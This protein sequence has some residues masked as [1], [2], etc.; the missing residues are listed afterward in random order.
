MRITIVLPIL[1]FLFLG[2]AGAILRPVARVPT[3]GAAGFE[4]IPSPIGPLLASAHFWDGKSADMSAPSILFTLSASPSGNLTLSELQRFPTKG[5]H[6]W[7]FFSIPGEFGGSFLV[8]CNYYGCGSERGPALGPCKST[9]IY[10]FREEEGRFVLFQELATAGPAQTDHIVLPSGEAYLLVGENFNDEVC[11]FRYTATQSSS[12]FA[13]FT[14]LRVPGAGAM[15]VAEAGG[16]I[17]L[18]L[19]SYFDSGWKTQS[20]VYRAATA[21]DN[22][23][24]GSSRD[25]P[26]GALQWTLHQTLPTFGAH[27]ADSALIGGTEYLFVSE[28]RDDASSRVSSG[29]YTLDHATGQYGL[30]Q[31]IPTDG[32]HGGEL[33][34]GPG[35]RPYLAIANFGDRQGARYAARSSVWRGEAGGGPFALVAEVQTQGATDVEHFA[36]SGRHYIAFAEE[37]NLGR[38]TFQRSYIYELTDAS[39]GSAAGEL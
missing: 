4:F 3:L 11:V 7:D 30:L 2:A 17:Y 37:G 14:C 32:A 6:G 16:F 10:R 23:T 31:R 18:S 28:D 36:L 25:A 24:R 12:S 21:T 29:L 34:E 19:A 20:P 38:R 26:P 15:A 8:T 35:G 27:D 5:A 1:L 39:T 13:K 33:F 22:T 9:S